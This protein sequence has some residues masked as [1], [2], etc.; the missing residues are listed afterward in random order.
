MIWATVS[1]SSCFYFIIEFIH[2]SCKEH[3]QPD[4]CSD[5][6]VMLILSH[7]L[8]CSK[9]CLLWPLHESKHVHG[10]ETCIIQWGYASCSIGPP[11]INW[12]YWRVLQKQSPLEKEMT[13]HSSIL[14]WR[15]SWTVWKGK[16]IYLLELTP[17]KNAL[18]IIGYWNTKVG[19]QEKHRIIR[20]F[21]LRVQNEAG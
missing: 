20:F 14:D 3:N 18:F 6:L 8:A 21:D 10:K 11:T 15:I 5:H 1:S 13:T 12:S 9:R 2:L 4:F 7:L 16:K 19:S 17:N